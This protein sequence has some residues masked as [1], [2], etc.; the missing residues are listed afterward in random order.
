MKHFV[1]AGLDYGLKKGC[2]GTKFRCG[3]LD[4]KRKLGEF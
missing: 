3:H 1:W 4:A 2:H